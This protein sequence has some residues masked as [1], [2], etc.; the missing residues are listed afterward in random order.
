MTNSDFSYDDFIGYKNVPRGTFLRLQLFT[1][2]LKKWQKTINLISQSTIS[3]IWNRHIIDSAQ[4]IDFIKG[5][6]V[7]D[8]G[9]GAGFPGLI[10]AILGVGEVTLVESDGRKAAFLREAARVTNSNVVIKNQRVEEVSLPDSSTITAR[11]FAS[12]NDTL[13]SLNNTLNNSHNILLLKGKNYNQEITEA[14]LHW[15]FDCD[16]I[17]S[18]T[19]KEAAILSL[20]HISRK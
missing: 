15:L 1:E 10:L 19:D 9:S 5:N 16:V 8:I 12:V 11:G 4:L 7:I 20:T 2:L 17:P 3:N 18:I 6:S 14:R 13:Y